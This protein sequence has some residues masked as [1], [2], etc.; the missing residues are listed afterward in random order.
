[1]HDHP[2]E[3]QQKI[4]DFI[5]DYMRTEAMPPTNREIG[6]AVGIRSTGHVDH[7]LSALEVMGLITRIPGR[8]RGIR[9]PERYG[10]P[11]LGTIAAGEPLDFYPAGEQ[12]M[13]DLGAHTVGKAYVLLVK[14]DSMIEDHISSGDYV[15]I[16]PN[17]AIMDGDIVVATKENNDTNEAG[18]ATLKRIYHE[19]GR[20]RLQPANST[21]QPIYV[22]AVEWDRDWK[23]QG[24]LMAVYRQ[25]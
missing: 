6:Q 20:I 17:A 13:L 10:V 11:I 12:A 8:S 15:L 19:T 3:R 4:Y 16:D 21:M 25:C 23:V 22:D 18:A 24:K 2:T 7:H 1:M 5:R 9:L 14:G